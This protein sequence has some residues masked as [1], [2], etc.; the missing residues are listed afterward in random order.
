MEE[1]LCDRAADIDYTDASPA[2]YEALETVRENVQKNTANEGGKYSIEESPKGRYVQADR[3]VLQGDDPSRWGKQIAEYINERIRNNEDVIFPTE[4]GH[5]LV[6]TGRSAYK[7]TE[8]HISQIAKQGRELLDDENFGLKM[9]AAA[10]IDELIQVGKFDRY[11]PDEDNS[12]EN[13]IGEDGFNYFNGFFRDFDGTHYRVPFSAGLN[14][15]DETVYSIGKIRERKSTARRG[16]SS[17]TMA[18]GA[19]SRRNRLSSGGIVAQSDSNVKEKTAI[20]LAFEKAQRKG[21]KLSAA[22]RNAAT[23]NLEA[24]E[25]AEHGSALPGR[26]LTLMTEIMLIQSFGGVL[27]SQIMIMKR[28]G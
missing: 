20:E 27:S 5:L 24:L 18:G 17:G 6:L 4:D 1:A 2:G 8:R 13:D 3:Q 11:A 23:A 21:K 28:T 19:Q 26:D 25:Q 15:N 9:R 22:G 12:H 14:E 7:L 10:H 16:P